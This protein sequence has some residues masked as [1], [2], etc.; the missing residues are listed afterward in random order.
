[1]GHHYIPRYYLRQFS[2]NKKQRQVW[3][4]DL[5]GSTPKRTSITNAA[6]EN[7]YYFESDEIAMANQIEWPAQE[8]MQK[9]RRKIPLTSDERHRMATYINCLIARVPAMRKLREDTLDTRFPSFL[10]DIVDSELKRGALSDYALSVLLLVID[11]YKTTGFRGLPEEAQ[12]ILTQTPWVGERVTN[13]LSSMAWLI[14]ST[15]QDYP[16]ICSDNPVFWFRWLGMA[17]KSAQITMP[18]SSTTALLM[19]HLPQGA[20]MQAFDVAPYV[21]DE[22]NHRTA[23]EA[24]RFLYARQD[25]EWLKKIAEERKES[26]QTLR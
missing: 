3:M 25:G 22:I 11:G 23:A 12:R 14:L 21:V 4:Y 15:G 8:P 26:F 20:I 13:L 9:L 24:T 10:D 5:D 1:M 18:L 7:G 17:D 2:V 16:F 6:N 19:V